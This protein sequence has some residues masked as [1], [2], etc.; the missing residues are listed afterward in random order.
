[1][2][3]IRLE[4]ESRSAFRFQNDTWN[5]QALYRIGKASTGMGERRCRS[6]HS[7]D[8]LEPDRYRGMGVLCF[9][10]HHLKS[11]EAQFV[12]LLVNFLN[13]R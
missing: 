10:V 1:M 12:L 6:R 8:R 11:W 13:G 5:G 2:V 3:G 4:R 7:N 9:H